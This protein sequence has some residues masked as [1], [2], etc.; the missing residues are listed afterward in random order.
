MR[1]SFRR[2][3]RRVVCST[4][5]ELVPSFPLPTPVKYLDS[6]RAFWFGLWR[7]LLTQG[8]SFSVQKPAPIV[9][10][11]SWLDPSPAAHVP[12]NLVATTTGSSAAGVE[13]PTDDYRQPAGITDE[14]SFFIFLW[15]EPIFWGKVFY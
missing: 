5:L 8:S 2:H 1:R 9:L 13:L 7:S 14:N 15:R 12:G 3:R 6:C 10:V 4:L 11:T